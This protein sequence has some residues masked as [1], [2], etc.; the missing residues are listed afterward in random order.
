[1]QTMGGNRQL[2][3]RSR[4]RAAC[5]LGL[6][7]DGSC[8]LCRLFLPFAFLSLLFTTPAVASHPQDLEFQLRLV[9]EAPVY[10]LGESILLEISYSASTKDKYQRSFNPAL[11]GIKIHVVPIDGVQ[12]LN[13]L[14][15]APAGSTTG[16]M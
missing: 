14:R 12:D 6:P 16:R 11:E 3:L 7:R 1:M 4:S 10:H 2:N 15:C 5:L 9:Q 8:H 13:L